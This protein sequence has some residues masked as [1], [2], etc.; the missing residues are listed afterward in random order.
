MSLAISFVKSLKFRSITSEV[1][2]I[3]TVVCIEVV[4]VSLI[5]ASLSISE[6][7]LTFTAGV[8]ASQTVS[9]TVYVIVRV[10]FSLNS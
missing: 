9:G 5:S 10:P 7:N 6:T 8:N 3:G 4:G 1:E 2:N